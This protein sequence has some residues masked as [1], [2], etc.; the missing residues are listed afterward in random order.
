MLKYD[1][2]LEANNYI[3]GKD[4]HGYFH[5]KISDKKNKYLY[6][7][8]RLDLKE[9]DIKEAINFLVEKGQ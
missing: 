1:I 7:V 8:K 9:T 5:S 2:I 6:K 4:C 3:I